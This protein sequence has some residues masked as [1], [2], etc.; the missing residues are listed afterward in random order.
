MKMDLAENIKPNKG[1]RIEKINSAVA[2][3]IV[4]DRAIKNEGN[5]VGSV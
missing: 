1:K 5:D 4:F 2:T 3:I